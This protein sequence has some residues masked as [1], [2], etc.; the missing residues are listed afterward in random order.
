[1][2]LMAASSYLTTFLR[3]LEFVTG[4]LKHDIVP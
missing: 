2:V 4:I 1:M 3:W